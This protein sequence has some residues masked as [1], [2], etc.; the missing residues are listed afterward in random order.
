MQCFQFFFLKSDHAIVDWRMS[1]GSLFHVRGPAT[2]MMTIYLQIWRCIFRVF[3]KHATWS[4]VA[5]V[6][7]ALVAFFDCDLTNM[8]GSGG[9]YVAGANATVQPLSHNKALVVYFGSHK[10]ADSRCDP[11]ADNT[12]TPIHRPNNKSHPSAN[13][14]CRLKRKVPTNKINVLKLYDVNTAECQLDVVIRSTDSINSSI[15]ES[16]RDNVNER[17][18]TI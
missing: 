3:R 13:D 14:K 15:Q 7:E 12:P 1:N 4:R 2:E 11:Y 6:D 17:W 16:E 5:S 9:L 10:S 8:T 18:L